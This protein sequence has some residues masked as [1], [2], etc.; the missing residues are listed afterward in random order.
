MNLQVQKID[1]YQETQ[2]RSLEHRNTEGKT[3]FGKE[4]RPFFIVVAMPFLH[5]SWQ[6][7]T[8]NPIYTAQDHIHTKWEEDRKVNLGKLADFKFVKQSLRVKN[9]QSPS[10][11]MYTQT[12]SIFHCLSELNFLAK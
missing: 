8:K 10:K 12:R 2:A 5:K 4:A 3:I 1:M 9:L 7:T 11:R 6:T